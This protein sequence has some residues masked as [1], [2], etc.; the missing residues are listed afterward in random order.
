M[1]VGQKLDVDK[2]YQEYLNTL[3]QCGE[4]IPNWMFFVDF[5]YDERSSVYVVPEK[6]AVVYGKRATEHSIFHEL[7]HLR[8]RHNEIAVGYDEEFEK[9]VN[10]YFVGFRQGG[11]DGLFLEEG[12]NELSARYW[13]LKAKENDHKAKQS[14]IEEYKKRNYYA[15]EIYTCIGLCLIL[16]L[17]VDEIRNSKYSGD[18]TC[19]NI[20]KNRVTYLTGDDKYWENM[21]QC[22]DSFEYAKRMEGFEASS[23]VRLNSLNGY[24]DLAYR[25]LFLALERKKIKTPEFNRRMML[26]DKYASKSMKFFTEGKYIAEKCKNKETAIYGNKDI[27]KYVW[28]GLNQYFN[29]IYSAVRFFPAKKSILTKYNHNFTGMKQ[30]GQP[31]EESFYGLM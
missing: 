19:Q 1:E 10:F 2:T 23:S 3:I 15:F 13:F 4:K 8:S 16:G 21:Q 28:T 7:E 24:Y 20:I 27:K 18:S 6:N 11:C 30:E 29:K 31:F 25:L 9:Y 5:I 14:A 12:F 17:N 22:L 26:F